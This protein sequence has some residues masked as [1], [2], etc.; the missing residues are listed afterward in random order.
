MTVDAACVIC[1]QTFSTNEPTLPGMGGSC[2]PCTRASRI[3]MLLRCC[4]SPGEPVWEMKL[5]PWEREFLTDVRRRQAPLTEAQ[6][7]KLEQIW[8]KS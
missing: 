4:P 6:H 7:E 1:Q 8:R 3:R 2:P 5:T